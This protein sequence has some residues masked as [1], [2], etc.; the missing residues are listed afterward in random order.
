MAAKLAG[1]EGIRL[2]H[3]QL[4]YKPPDVGQASHIGWHQD[5]GYWTCIDLWRTES[6]PLVLRSIDIMDDQPDSS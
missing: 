3:D 2:V 6:V 4:I 1:T 5:L